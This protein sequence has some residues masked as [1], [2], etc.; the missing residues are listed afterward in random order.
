M[1][2]VIDILLLFILRRIYLGVLLLG[3]PI[4]ELIFLITI[5]SRHFSKRLVFQ[6]FFFFSS[7]ILTILFN[8]NTFDL[9]QDSI[10]NSYLLLSLIFL[11]LI[12][13]LDL[14]K[15]NELTILLLCATI[16]LI[17]ILMFPPR[18]VFQLFGIYSFANSTIFSVLYIGYGFLSQKRNTGHFVLIILGVL[19]LLLDSQRG[20][21]LSLFLL[22][23]LFKVKK[24]KDLF[25]FMLYGSFLVLI[26][27]W[28]IPYFSDRDPTGFFMSIFYPNLYADSYSS[29]LHRIIQ[30]EEGI[31]SLTT[32]WSNFLFGNGPSKQ[33]F[34]GYFNDIHNGYVSF[35]SIVGIPTALYFFYIVFTNILK[36]LNNS[37]N[38]FS[39][40]FVILCFDALTQTTF[41]SVPTVSIF[42]YSLRQLL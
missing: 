33:V 34:T 21:Y 26:F 41:S 29:G 32:S 2:R 6:S 27:L 18:G 19:I 12:P 36:T 9:N 8:L 25:F 5:R 17:F 20:A 4:R 31:N 11:P 7:L 28:L 40:L 23:F 30:I 10:E 42:I 16:N 37:P 15:K 24:I 1:F 39:L 22:L 35:A 3:L 14:S 38:L 13:K